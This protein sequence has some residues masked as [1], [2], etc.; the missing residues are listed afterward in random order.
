MSA[1]AADGTVAMQILHV[2][3]ALCL[4]WPPKEKSEG[5]YGNVC[6][7]EGFPVEHYK[8]GQVK[9]CAHSGTALPALAQRAVWDQHVSSHSAGQC[10]HGG[11]GSDLTSTWDGLPQSAVSSKER[12]LGGQ[13]PALKHSHVVFRWGWLSSCVA[14]A[15]FMERSCDAGDEVKAEEPLFQT[16]LKM[17]ISFRVPPCFLRTCVSNES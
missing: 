12:C 8:R 9:N 5:I 2:R 11:E 10:P 6:L 4:P 14:K 13:T 15:A 3:E 17:L 1:R 16:L 7:L